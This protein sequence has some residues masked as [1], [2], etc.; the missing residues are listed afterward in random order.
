MTLLV[1]FQPV[2]LNIII[3]N[4][5]PLFIQKSTVIMFMLYNYGPF[6]KPW[7]VGCSHLLPSYLS[8]YQCRI[9]SYII[10]Y[11]FV[12][13]LPP[14]IDCIKKH[15]LKP[16]FLY[17]W[18]FLSQT[19]L[20]EGSFLLSEKSFKYHFNIYWKYILVLDFVFVLYA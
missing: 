1:R 7:Q 12:T 17:R 15:L 16:E 18:I 14:K 8:L 11:I 6:L 2:S 5:L 20:C 13:P 9:S 19:R 4:I 3:G 10:I